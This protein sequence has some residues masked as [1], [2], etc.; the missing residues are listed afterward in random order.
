MS[1]KKRTVA[2]PAPVE[3]RPRPDLPALLRGGLFTNNPLLVSMLGLTL[4]LAA[5]THGAA[6]LAI[7]VSTAAVLLI[8]G[9]A[10]S[11]FGRFIPVKLRAA[12][13][14]LLGAGL[15]VG[16]E[17]ALGALLPDVLAS[18]GIFVALISTCGLILSR[19]EFACVNPPHAA[20]VDALAHGVG[21]TAALTL[22]GVIREALGAGTVFG[23]DVTLGVI[24]PALAF[25][26]PVGGLLV[27]GLLAAAAQKLLL[28]REKKRPPKPTEPEPDELTE[29][30]EPAEAAESDGSAGSTGSDSPGPASPETEEV[31]A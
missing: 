19:A 12:V 15:T 9:L 6:S 18:L 30:T 3:A 31:S 21:F 11:L 7:G 24:P 17:A 1:E 22:V 2:E 26:A 20:L 5:G 16:V 14:T 8:T 23:F 29:P 10:A 25:G 28:L 4:A 13:F 27:V